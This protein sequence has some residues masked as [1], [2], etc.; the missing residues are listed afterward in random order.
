MWST[1]PF[2]FLEPAFEMR[3]SVLLCELRCRG[4]AKGVFSSL[5]RRMWQGSLPRARQSAE[6]TDRNEA[7]KPSSPMSAARPLDRK[8]CAQLRLH[9]ASVADVGRTWA[10]CLLEVVR[11]MARCGADG[12]PPF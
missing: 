12:G 5:V 1:R 3:V 11:A 2:L 4:L 7:S 9:A 10:R 8:G 6:E